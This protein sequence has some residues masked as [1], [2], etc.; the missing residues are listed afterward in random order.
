MH[1]ETRRVLQKRLHTIVE[2]EKELKDKL[3]DTERNI[4][5]NTKKRNTIEKSLKDLAI[6]KRKITEDIGDD[7]ID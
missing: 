4:D 6:E 3:V 2:E 7:K 1:S 5:L